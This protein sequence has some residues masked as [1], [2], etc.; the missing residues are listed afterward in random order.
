MILDKNIHV[1][2]YET[3]SNTKAVDSFLSLAKK[4][5][6]KLVAL[7]THGRLGFMRFTLGSFAETA[8]HRSKIDLLLANP[9]TNFSP[10]VKSIFYASDFSPSSK[11][12][13]KRVIEISKKIGAQLTVFHATEIIYKLSFDELNPEIVS[14][15]NKLR[16]IEVWI[17]QEC[18]KL[19]VSCKVII[20]SEFTPSTELALNNAKKAR[21]DLIVVSAKVGPMAAL[22]GGSVTRYI[23]RASTKP[24]LV[25]K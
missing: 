11:K 16:R 7:Y 25:L 8:I 1:V 24:V 6:T 14:Y 18:K 13:L 9:E 20:T 4:R 17:E 5:N 12:H 10:K 21:A 2:D 23:V 15:R 22:M 19:E 3:F